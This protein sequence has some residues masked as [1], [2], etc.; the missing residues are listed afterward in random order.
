[1]ASYSATAFDD[2]SAFSVTA[3]DFVV[4]PTFN[5]AF[6]DG[7]FGRN[8]AFSDQAFSFGVTPPIP[9]IPPVP[10]VSRFPGGVLSGGE[11]DEWL[12]KLRR[13]FDQQNADDMEVVR[14]LTEFLSRL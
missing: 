1:M 2:V 10:I 13:R 7:A 4:V 11:E 9:P 3:F 8:T 14:L 5:P 12:R 6:S